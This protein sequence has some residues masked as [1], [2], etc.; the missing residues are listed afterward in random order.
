MMLGCGSAF[1]TPS[2]FQIY[3]YVEAEI[4]PHHG[5]SS[6]V[7]GFSQVTPQQKCEGYDGF[8]V[9]CQACTC[10]KCSLSSGLLEV[11]RALPLKP[12]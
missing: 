2:H 7:Y 11:F 10:T 4:E 8:S 12:D 3:A 1:E 6:L 5:V 9:S